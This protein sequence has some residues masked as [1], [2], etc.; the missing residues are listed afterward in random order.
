M[1][2]GSADSRA[3][4]TGDDAATPKDLKL[5]LA[6]QSLVIDWRDGVS[7]RFALPL[8]RRHCP[9]A[10]C[11]TERDKAPSNPFSILKSD[12]STIHV[13]NAQLVGHYAL[14]LFWSD[15]HQTGIYEFRFLR[16]LADESSGQV[17]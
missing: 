5:K 2:S 17:G 11:R 15:G 4:Q 6:E 16:Q 12:P 1:S 8:L 9:C 10:T 7:S 14:Q 3:P 13:T